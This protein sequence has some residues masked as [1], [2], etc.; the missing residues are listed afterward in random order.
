MERVSTQQLGPV[1]LSVEG[2]HL[3]TNLI[4]QKAPALAPARNDLPDLDAAHRDER[5]ATWVDAPRVE[6]DE[7]LDGLEQR[8]VG[9]TLVR[10]EAPLEAVENASRLPAQQGLIHTENLACVRKDAGVLVE[11]VVLSHA[12]SLLC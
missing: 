8:R 3:A 4:E 11:V 7:G 5:A 9:A 12:D 1:G 6:L 10:E 2:L